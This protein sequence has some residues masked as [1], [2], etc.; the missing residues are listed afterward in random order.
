MTPQEF[1]RVVERALARITRDFAAAW[2]MWRWWWSANP[3]PS[4]LVRRVSA[5]VRCWGFTKA[6]R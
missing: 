4:N 5:A 2:R 6:G 1:D 3:R